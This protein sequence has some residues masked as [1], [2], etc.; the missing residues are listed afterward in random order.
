MLIRLTRQ[1]N[2]SSPTGAN[3]SGCF[4]FDTALP[5]VDTATGIDRKRVKDSGDLYS[6]QNDIFP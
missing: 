5:A 4:R 1:R 2:K 3:R 6:D